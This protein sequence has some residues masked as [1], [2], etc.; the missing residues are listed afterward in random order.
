MELA[1]QPSTRMRL[2]PKRPGQEVSSLTQGSRNS[3][4]LGNSGRLCSLGLRAIPAERRRS[5]IAGLPASRPSL[6]E[7][8]GEGVHALAI[9]AYPVWRPSPLLRPEEA[10]SCRCSQKLPSGGERTSRASTCHDNPGSSYSPA[11]CSGH[12]THKG[13]WSLDCSTCTYL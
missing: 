12:Q 13:D 1:P 10:G 8:Y 4:P 7:A 3:I 2:L 6:V 11:V 5:W 9:P